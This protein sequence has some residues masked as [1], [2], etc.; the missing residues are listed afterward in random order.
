MHWVHIVSCEVKMARR[1]GLGSLFDKGAILSIYSDDMRRRVE[2]AVMV[3]GGAAVVMV[4]YQMLR[5]EVKKS[6]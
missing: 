3:V 4:G 1:S 6:R 5:G 2:N